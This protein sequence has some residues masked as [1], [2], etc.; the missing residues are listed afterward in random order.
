MKKR[1]I[2]LL[3][4]TIMLFSLIACTDNLQK[5]TEVLNTTETD[6]KDSSKQMF[7]ETTATDAQ[8]PTVTIKNSCIYLMVGSS[9]ELNFDVDKSN[10]ATDEIIWSSSTNSVSIRDGV[11]VA[12]KEGY[13]YVSA[14]GGNSCLVCVIPKNMSKMSINTNGTAI[15]SKELY[16]PCTVSLSTDNSAFSFTNASAGI[17][18]RG[19]S[20][21]GYAKKPYRISFDTKRNVLGM[22]GGAEFKSWVLLAEW[23]DDSMLRNTMALSM[24]SMMLGEYSS[25][26]RYVSLDI[27]GNYNGVYVL[28]EQSQINKNRIDIEEAGI[29]SSSLMS[30]YLFEV[31]A[32]PP[33]ESPEKFKIYHSQYDIYNLEN[34]PF[35]WTC[36]DENL[37]LQRIAL[38]NEGYSED[39]FLFAK[40][41]LRSVFHIIYK[42]TYDGE[43]YT[44]ANN[45]LNN[46]ERASAFLA[47]CKTDNE[48]KLVRNYNMTP[49][50]AVEAVVDTESLAKMYLFSEL[51][52]NSDDLKKSF[53]MWVDFS[54]DGS[55]KLTFGCPWDHDGAIVLW[56]SVNTVYNPTDEYFAAKRNPWYV[57]VMCNDW[58][59]E[60]VKKYWREMYDGNNG[61]N[62]NL[63]LITPITNSYSSE[64]ERDALLWADARLEN[65]REQAQITQL[66]LKDR[67]LW[68]NSKFGKNY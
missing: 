58:F 10:A 59:V 1:I 26:W 27:N 68:L 36:N 35:Q 15:T 50:Q 41:Y 31:D 24:A 53:Y 44:F 48:I 54:E 23:L 43:A 9:Q 42:A 14:N 40:F 30:G 55:G 6:S 17:R 38:K 34:E 25:D 63:E 18:V 61:F 57:M 32:S 19:N 4:A 5:N 45:F 16:T 46:P 2:G 39:Q 29:K 8:S 60:D 22:N 28:C 64:F 20:T 37:Y 3:L 56:D 11:V 62:S 12:E 33:Y 52:C 65:Q 47:Q 51:I 7:K 49:Q 21:A 67:I 13:S 66:W